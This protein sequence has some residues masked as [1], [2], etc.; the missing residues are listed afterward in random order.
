LV[1]FL[2]G[3]RLDVKTPSEHSGARTAGGSLR[4]TFQIIS[5]AN[6]TKVSGLRNV[7]ESLHPSHEKTPR[8]SDLGVFS[9]HLRKVFLFA[10]IM[11]CT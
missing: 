5:Y 3:S 11:V 6:S 7:T 9:M 1:G 10:M 2:R 4:E 8:S